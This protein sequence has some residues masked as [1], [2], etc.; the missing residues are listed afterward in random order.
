MDIILIVLMS[1]VSL[2]GIS[3]L[4]NTY[5][6]KKIATNYKIEELKQIKVI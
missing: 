1:G 6:L 4:Y 5:V 2:G 3:L